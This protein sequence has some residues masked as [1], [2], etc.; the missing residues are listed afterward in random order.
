MELKTLHTKN[1][2]FIQEPYV[3]KGKICL[4]PKERSLFSGGI[5]PRAAILASKDVNLWLMPNLSSRDVTTCLWETGDHEKPKVLITS[6][7]MD[8]LNPEVILEEM[9]KITDY[10]EINK[11]PIISGIDSN[12]HSQLWGCPDSN[13][14]GEKLEEWLFINNLSVLNQNTSPT[15]QTVRAESIIDISIASDGI[16]DWFGGWKVNETHQFSDHKRI[17]FEIKISFPIT[18]PIRNLEKANW[19]L[20]QSR[21][22][23]NT[24][25]PPKSWT[26]VSLDQEAKKIQSTI[27]KAL[28]EA[29]PTKMVKISPKPKP[30]TWW[31]EKLAKMRK[32]VRKTYDLLKNGKAS[33]EKFTALRK[34]YSKEVKKS[35]KDS[36]IEFCGSFENIK[37]ISSFNKI[38]SKKKSPT[39]GLLKNIDGSST[40]SG[41]ETLNLLM[42]THFPGSGPKNRKC[43]RKTK[44]TTDKINKIT[45]SIITIEKI[46]AALNQFDAKK[47]AGP[48][49]FKPIILQKLPDKMILRIQFIYRAS[50]ALAHVPEIWCTSTVVFLPKPGKDCY[51]SPKSFRPISMSPFLLKC[52]ERLVLWEL[53][54]T[55]LE[56]NP[57]SRFQHAFRRDRGTDTALSEVV[58]KI[59]S[60]LLRGQYTLGVFLDIQGAFDNLSIK[61]AIIGMKNRGF[62]PLITSWYGYYLSNRCAE[63]EVQGT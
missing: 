52:L 6:V 5:N 47:T 62:P 56:S 38:I 14:R 11:I 30:I 40:N 36:W 54:S 50:L 61:S 55:A 26:R 13:T 28:E 42:D 17:E 51:Q 20:F 7:Y 3:S 63:I 25:K 33:H 27:E 31:N 9:N 57:L 2:Q 35:K 18:K 53:E 23:E 15:F 49:G 24:W 12:S 48:D 59:E 60:G 8:I 19:S 46:K 37:D 58:D 4:L 41:L 45:S 16:V 1:I 22:E 29:C 21:L 44:L 10:A 32:E 39:L 34:T 43:Y